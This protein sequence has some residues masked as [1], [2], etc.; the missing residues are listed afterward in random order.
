MIMKTGGIIEWG[1]YAK[2][3]VENEGKIKPV[4]MML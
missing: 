4:G 1:N 3:N 2:E